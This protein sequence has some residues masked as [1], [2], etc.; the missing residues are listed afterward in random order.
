MINYDTNV[1]IE[2]IQKLLDE[3][4]ISQAEFGKAI[5]VQQSRISTILNTNNS[6]CF[7]V[8]QLVNIATFFECSVDSLLY[9]EKENKEIQKELD[10]TDICKCIAY[11][12]HN[13]KYNLHIHDTNITECDM[14]FDMMSGTP[15]FNDTDRQ[16]NTLYFSEQ[17]NPDIN[18]EYAKLINSFISK[19]IDIENIYTKNALPDDMYNRLLAS[20]INDI[21]TE[22][23]NIEPL[24]HIPTH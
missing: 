22:Y 14:Y 13:K 10:I 9:K 16:Y 7:T 20:Y 6:N 8:Q 24:A 21:K 12:I 2:N 5:N 4:N 11:L 23:E 15:R 1:L 18:N 19:I 3:K 17:E